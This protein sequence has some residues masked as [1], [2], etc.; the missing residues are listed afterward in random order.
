MDD[1]DDDTHQHTVVVFNNSCICRIIFKKVQVQERKFPY[2]FRFSPVNHRMSDSNHEEPDPPSQEEEADTTP[3]NNKSQP[4]SS[5]SSSTNQGGTDTVAEIVSLL[6]RQANVSSNNVVTSSDAAGASARTVHA[7]GTH[8]HAF[9]DTQ[10]M[11][12]HARTTTASTVLSSSSSSTPSPHVHSLPSNLSLLSSTS[13]STSS[14]LT[15]SM[16]GPVIPDKAVS[17]IRAEPY[18]MPKG[19]VWSNVDLTQSTQLEELY[20]LLANNYVEDTDAIFRFDYS[21]NFLLWALTPPGYQAQYHIGVRS[22]LTGKLVAFISGVPAHIRV[23]H[24][25]RP[26]VEINFLCV[27]KKLRSKRLAPVLIKEIT[28]RVNLSGVYQ[29][30][31]T[32]GVVLPVPVSSCRYWHRSLHVKKLVEVGFT[33]I[34]PRMT[35]ARMTKLYKLPDETSIEGLRPMEERDVESAHALLQEHLTKFQLV[36]DFSVEDFR[37]WLF[38]RKGVIS[39]FVVVSHD[40]IVTDLISF[41]HLPSSITGS[42]TKYT[43]LRAA[44]SFYNVATTVDWVT[45]M[46]DALVLAK[47]GQEEEE[48]DVFNALSQMCNDEFIEPLKFGKGD[49]NLQYY[50]YNW[51]CPPIDCKDVGIVLL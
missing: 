45:L 21:S 10:P 37:H 48:A 33:R 23:Y 30:V 26:M 32:A 17:E 12:H 6:R 7:T 24:V 25:T 13:A 39:S 18:N 46:R 29:A 15:P 36:V 40:N 38:P 16:H 51:A 8:H 44:F 19:Y 20:Q 14:S 42:T 5:S 9:W 11:L 50:L 27:H 34:P 1:D 43:H 3:N 2:S 49:G 47:N 22:V 4:S 41:Y 28:R 35:L 31:Y